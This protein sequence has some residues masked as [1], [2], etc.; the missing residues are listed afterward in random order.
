MPLSGTMK[1]ACHANTVA[2]FLRNSH[3]IVNV[4]L[5]KKGEE[6]CK[7]LACAIFN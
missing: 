5:V 2:R 1:C 4:D 3:V 6:V 7:T